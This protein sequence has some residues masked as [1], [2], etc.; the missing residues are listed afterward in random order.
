MKVCVLYSGGKDSTYSLHWAVFKGFEVICLITLLPKREDSWMFQ[1]PNVELTKYQ[2]EVL[3]IPLIQKETSG[4]KDKELN[5]L[6]EAFKEAKRNGAEGIITG[7]L[8]SDYQRLNINLMAEEVGLKTYSPLWRKDQKEYLRELVKEGFKFIITSAS[9]YGFPF[10][11]V[12][13]IIDEKDIERIIVASEKYGF[14]PAF[15]GGEAET[16]VVY[17]PLF[18]R[19]L[20]VEGYKKKLGE[21]EWRF[22]L[23]R[24]L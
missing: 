17:A 14:N 11:L 1:V 20:K 9:A 2:A 10:E 21:Y 4:E 16:F 19:E 12:G 24:I 23:T 6:K 7:A 18:K 5:D 3:G 13:K 15:E 22:I 8:L